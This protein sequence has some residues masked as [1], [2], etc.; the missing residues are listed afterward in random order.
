M[1]WGSLRSAT[2]AAAGSR[3]SVAGVVRGRLPFERRAAADVAPSV[4]SVPVPLSPAVTSVL[5]APPLPGAA[6]AACA[7]AAWQVAL[8]RLTGEPELVLRL[9]AS[10]AREPRWVVAVVDEGASFATLASCA[11][12]ALRGGSGTGAAPEAGFGLDERDATRSSDGAAESPVDGSGTETPADV[13]TLVVVPTS[14]AVRYDSVRVD[15]A[16]ARRLAAAVASVLEQGLAAP[17][18]PAAAL[19]VLPEEERARLVG[20]PP[21]VAPPSDAC[22]HHLFERQVDRAPERPAL[23]FEGERLTYAELDARANQIAHLVRRHGAGSDTCVAMCLDRS[24]DMI[25]ALLGILKAGAAYVPLLADA[26]KARLAQQLADIRAPLLFTHARFVEAIPDFGGAVVCLDRDRVVVERESRSRPPATGRPSDLAYVI[27]TSGSTGTPK[28]VAVQHD[29]LVNYTGYLCRRLELER[30]E[31]EGGLSFAT[32]STLAADLGNTCVFP[33]LASGGCLHVIGHDT[34]MD[35]DRFGAYARENPIDVLKITPSHLAALIAFPEG[36]HVL[37]R[38]FL[39][40][41]GEASTWP[42][43]DRVRALS[44]ARWINHYGPTET[45][46]GS[47]TFDV[48]GSDDVRALASTVPIGR[49]IANTRVYVLDERREPVPVGVAG[50]LFIGGRG[51]TRGYLG[52]T[53]LTDERFLPDP[54]AGEP[55][56]RMYKTG[57]R[58]RRLPGDA[59]EFLGRVDHQIKLRGFRVELGEIEAVLRQSPAVRETIVVAREDVPGDLRVVAYVVPT[60]RPAPPP[61]DLKAFVGA[62]LPPF[63]VPSAVV[64]LDALPLTANGKVDRKALPAPVHVSSASAA[65]PAMEAGSIE[66]RIA[67]IWRDVLGLRSVAAGDDFFAVGGHS[68]AALHVLARIERE[69]GKKVTHADLIRFPTIAGLAQV[70]RGDAATQHDFA[71]LVPLQ[72]NGTRPPLFC[73]HGGG[74]HVYYYRDLSK[75]LG[76]DQPFYGL[77]GRHVDGKLPPLYTV[78]EMAEFYLEEIRSVAPAGPYFLCGASFGGKVAFEIAKIL[79]RRG[80]TVGL[81]AMFDTWGPGYPRFRVGPVLQAAG[82]LYRRVEHH[83]GSLRLLEPHER[84]AYL[85]DKAAK[86]D[87]HVRE[88]L[89]RTWTRLRRGRGVDPAHEQGPDLDEGFIR[90][91]SQAYAP[92]P[93]TGKVVLFRSLEQPLGVEPDPAMGWGPLVG[94]LEIHDVPGLHAA[95]VM[96]PR[97]RF[98]VDKFAVCL[99]AAQRAAEARPGR[100]GPA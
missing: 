6:A 98:L 67:E 65:G 24:A 39:V 77:Q 40:T 75:R 48:D 18:T 13:A 22:F 95:V 58:V 84:S 63:M 49:P 85:R 76:P 72:P 81:V 31:R 100:P 32:V 54:F 34:S 97:V 26:P 29:N 92:G 27:F 93:Y 83:V 71:S 79:Q 51:V 59:I 35:G 82:W 36:R 1:S 11:E 5:A 2:V 41:G 57:D 78:E 46:I 25:V 12:Q 88:A 17:A 96:E 89:E 86:T 30:W 53:E 60:T 91:A 64:P 61:A 9:G 47:L 10:G 68:L 45:T 80:E 52:R 62:R 33:A 37:P 50:E 16:D 99:R 19:P 14:L 70:V 90:I 3:S 87:V 38:R 20:P 23:A 42:L 66:G 69:L 56:A 7:L 94:D 44:S 4:R 74:G 8:W 15:A 43:V 55:G 28:G 21:V 73:V